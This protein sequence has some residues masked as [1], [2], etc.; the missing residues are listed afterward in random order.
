ML[1]AISKGIGHWKYERYAPWLTHT[2]RDVETI[3]L[4]ALSDEDAIAA[5]QRADGVVFS[6]GPDIDPVHYA[7]PEYAPQC[8]N[9][10]EASRMRDVRELQ[11]FQNAIQ[12]IPTLGTC[13]GMQ[14]ANVAFGGTL[15]PQLSVAASHG[16]ETG[17]Q[18]HPIRLERGSLLAT[19]SVTGHIVNSAH[20]QGLDCI[21]PMFRVT[22]RAPDETVETL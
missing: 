3:E 13:R 5:L 21:A 6:G 20:H 9:I 16:K 4:S 8:Q 14:L 15:I 2:R 12:R 10:D 11:W 18:Q 19:G 7:H 17:D 22:A 1:I